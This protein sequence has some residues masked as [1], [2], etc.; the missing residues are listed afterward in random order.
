[1]ELKEIQER[2]DLEKCNDS[3]I[4]GKDTCGEYEF[5][6]CCDKEEEYPCANARVRY[7]QAAVEA[8]VEETPAPEAEEEKEKIFYR[9]AVIRPV[10]AEAETEDVLSSEEENAVVEVAE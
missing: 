2:F 3:R 7:E 6:V 9:L 5:C 8:P 10:R 1:M 4:A